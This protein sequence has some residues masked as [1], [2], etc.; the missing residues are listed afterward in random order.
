MCCG[1]CSEQGLC[2]V[3][4]EGKVSVFCGYCKEQWL[5]AVVTVWN[6]GNVLVVL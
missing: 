3:A 4:T 5:C 1:Y 6:S 2:A